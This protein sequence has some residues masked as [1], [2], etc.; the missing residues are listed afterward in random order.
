MPPIRMVK[1]SANARKKRVRATR[2]ESERCEMAMPSATEKRT[3]GR[4]APSSAALKMLAGR[5]SS[6]KEPN[7]GAATEGIENVAVAREAVAYDL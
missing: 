6:R 4:R 2:S 3:R 1:P 7:V 5:R